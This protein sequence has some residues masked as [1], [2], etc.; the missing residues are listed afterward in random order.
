MASSCKQY[1]DQ[2]ENYS[3][4]E[5]LVTKCINKDSLQYNSSTI[6]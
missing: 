5:R 4:I 3:S 1:Y 2:T 6:A